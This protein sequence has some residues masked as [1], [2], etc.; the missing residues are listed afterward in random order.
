MI[1]QVIKNYRTAAEEQMHASLTDEENEDFSLTDEEDENFSKDSVQK[2]KKIPELTYLKNLEINFIK[3]KNLNGRNIDRAIRDFKGILEYIEKDHPFAHY[4]LAKAY[5]RKGDY[6]L[7]KQHL[8]KAFDILADPLNK[9]WL[10][11]F[12]KLVPKNEMNEMGH[13][14]NKNKVQAQRT[15]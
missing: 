13:L 2:N 11:Y 6:K 12:H 15:A 14:M 10:E 3:N 5:K 4:C 7:V 1:F 8:D 9:K